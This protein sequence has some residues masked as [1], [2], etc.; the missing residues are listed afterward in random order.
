MV[1]GIVPSKNGNR[2]PSKSGLS[3]LYDCLL[4]PA[5]LSCSLP[6]VSVEA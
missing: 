3:S 5:S 4:W 1:F 6:F 2:C